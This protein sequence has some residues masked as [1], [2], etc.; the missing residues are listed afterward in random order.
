LYCSEIKL[1]GP[2]CNLDT[3]VKRH[4]SY[5]IQ[6]YVSGEYS[7]PCDSKSD[8]L[9][10]NS[11]ISDFSNLEEEKLSFSLSKFTKRERVRQTR[12]KQDIFF[13]EIPLMTEEGTFLING[14]ERVIISQIIR[15]PGIYFRKE[16]GISSF[17]A[18]YSATIISNK[19]LWTKFILDTPK[20]KLKKVQM[21]EE[22]E[23]IED[24]I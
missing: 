11:E 14:C 3:C 9:K 8:F 16:F 15:S 7:Y 19:G 18:N 2:N 4:I 13:G 12:V 6:I 20:R 22:E 21:S 17:K 5:T 24:R 10:I 1:K 23:Q